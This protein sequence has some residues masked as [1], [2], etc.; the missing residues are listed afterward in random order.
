MSSEYG[1]YYKTVKALPVSLKSLT[2]FKLFP[3]HVVD[4]DLNLIRKVIAY[5]MPEGSFEEATEVP[6]S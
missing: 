6:R 4:Q 2:L 5:G 1:T 3:F